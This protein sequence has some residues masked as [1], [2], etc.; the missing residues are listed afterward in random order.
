MALWSK[1]EGGE[2]SGI[3]LY[4]FR[5]KILVLRTFPKETIERGHKTVHLG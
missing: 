2:D 1:P 4:S 5:P 3:D